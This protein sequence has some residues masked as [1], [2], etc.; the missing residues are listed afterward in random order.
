LTTAEVFSLLEEK[1][2]QYNQPVF[3]G[4]DPVS[5]PHQFTLKQDIEIA[6]FLSA[7]ISWGNRISIV[8]N[9]RKLLQMMGDS[10]YEFITHA[11]AADFKPFLKFVHRTFNGEDCLFFLNSL[12]NIYRHYDSLEPLFGGM[13]KYGAAYAIHNF[14]DIF[15]STV[16]LGRSEK[17]VANP[18]AGSAAKRLNMFL[19]WMIRRDEHG[20]DFGLWRSID[21]ANLVCPLDIHAGRVARSLGLLKRSQNDWKAAM[22]LTEALREFDPSDPV[23]Y[24][25]ALF[26]IGVYS[27][28]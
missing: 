12:Q 19:R 9:A 20:V 22:E 26:G 8:G 24:D 16:H 5:V 6:G 2:N 25:F 1:Y 28:K 27:D 23:K 15:L 7:T 4:L 14:R 11:R 10:P 17:H 3:I 21:P 13:N 18:M